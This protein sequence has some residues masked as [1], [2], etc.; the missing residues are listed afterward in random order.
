MAVENRVADLVQAFGSTAETW[1]VV[2]LA[3]LHD[4]KY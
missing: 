3:E 2:S 4:L 1:E